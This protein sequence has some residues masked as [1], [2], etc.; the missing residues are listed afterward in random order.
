[1]RWVHLVNISQKK[2]VFSWRVNMLRLS[3]GSRRLS[4]SEFQDDGTATAK[5]YCLTCEI[6]PSCT[7]QGA[8]NK[9]RPYLRLALLMVNLT[10]F[11]AKWFAGRNSV[12]SFTFCCLLSIFISTSYLSS[13]SRHF[14]NSCSVYRVKLRKQRKGTQSHKYRLLCFSNMGSRPR[15]TDFHKNWQ[16]CRG[17]QHNLGFNIFRSLKTTRGQNFLFPIDLKQLQ[18]CLW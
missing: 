9:Q 18:Q 1:M 6:G 8:C 13:N 17:R 4:G 11:F 14:A 2:Y 10:L 3:A 15:W 16:V 5:Q 7:K 12:S